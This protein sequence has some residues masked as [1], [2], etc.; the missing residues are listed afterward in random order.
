MSHALHHRYTPVIP[1]H[2]LRKYV[3]EALGWSY[4]PEL[5]A[6]HILRPLLADGMIFSRSGKF[7]FKGS[8]MGL[9]FEKQKF[10][11]DDITAVIPPPPPPNKYDNNTHEYDLWNLSSFGKSITDVRGGFQGVVLTLDHPMQF[12]GKTIIR[13][14][15]GRLNPFKINGLKRVG[16]ASL[17]FERLFEVYSTDQVEAQTLLSPDFISRLIDFDEDYMGRNIQCVFLGNKFH[18][19]LDIDDKFNF[20]D[21]FKVPDYQDAATRI[22]HEIGAIFHLLE[23]VQA[24]QARIGRDGVEGADQKRNAYYRALLENLRLAISAAADK[25]GGSLPKRSAVFDSNESWQHLLLQPRI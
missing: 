3:Y 7:E 6:P 17:E 8:V 21:D 19:C 4:A 10:E 15:R 24:L 16:F 2:S 18:V 14:D 13:R 22:T 20:S 1:V 9:A 11:L 5:G 25:F 23:K 12:S